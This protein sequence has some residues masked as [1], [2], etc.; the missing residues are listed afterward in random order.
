MSSSPAVTSM[1]RSMLS[2]RSQSR[3]QSY[4]ALLSLPR[5]SGLLPRPRFLAALPAMAAYTFPAVW[6]GTASLCIQ[7]FMSRPTQMK[8]AIMKLP[9]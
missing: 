4:I 9:P 5:S 1:T 6:E 2:G 3:A 8:L 7:T